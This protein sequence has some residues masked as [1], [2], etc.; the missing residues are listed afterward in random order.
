MNVNSLLL[1]A[2]AA[3]LCFL[4]PAASAGG[5]GGGTVPVHTSGEEMF[6]WGLAAILTI[7]K[8]R[9]DS[10]PKT[11]Q[12][13][14]GYA[15][16]RMDQLRLPSYEPRAHK[17]HHA[18]QLEE[19][20]NP[21]ALSVANSG[22]PEEKDLPRQLLACRFYTWKTGTGNGAACEFQRRGRRHQRTNAQINNTLMH[23][24]EESQ[25]FALPSELIAH[26]FC[27]DEQVIQGRLRAGDSRGKNMEE[28]ERCHPVL[29][30]GAMNAVRLCPTIFEE[31][32]P[33]KVS[34]SPANICHVSE[35]LAIRLKGFGQSR[36]RIK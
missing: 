19:L 3:L 12:K 15:F 34:Y 32:S 31:D 13:V 6:R 21:A 33:A 14:T 9:P 29:V 8:C 7:G 5:G 18:C 17:L 36:E 16:P 27:Y 25:S 24:I 10:P 28:L 35:G 1:V 22:F 26:I 20:H 2:S 4:V 11:V 30:L 23:P